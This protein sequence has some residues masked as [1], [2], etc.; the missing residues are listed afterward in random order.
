MIKRE[1]QE[2][3][4]LQHHMMVAWNYHEQS[5]RTKGLLSLIK[6]RIVR[7]RERE[8]LGVCRDNVQANILRFYFGMLIN[9]YRER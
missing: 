4:T 1:R 6:Y 5:L 3:R 7:E 9:K 8:Q 2:E